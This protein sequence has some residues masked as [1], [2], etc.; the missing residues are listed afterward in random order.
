MI[1]FNC[2]KQI[3]DNSETCPSCGRPIVHREQLGKEISLRRYQRWFFY[4]VL[5]LIFLGMI[6]AIVKIYNA[7]TKLLLSVSSVQKELEEAKGT[8]GTTEAEL[9]QR[10]ELLKQVQADLLEKSQAVDVKTEE[11]KTVLNEKTAIEEKYSQSQLDLSSAEA[12]I[13]NLIIRLGV[14]ISNENLKK[15]PVADANLEGDDTDGDGLSD[16]AEEALG[17]DAAK[18]DTDGDGYNDKQEI[19]TGFN[20]LGAGNLGIDMDFANK[21]KGKILLQVE[22]HGEAWYV[23]TG[24]GERYFLGKPADAFRIMRSVEYWTKK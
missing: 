9:A 6:L 22:G 20:P 11:F 5:V 3:P 23:N 24:D 15:I 19:L 16:L 14:G 17:T 2:R 21:Q 1:C 7:N 10:E 4:G 13:Y 8:L 12:N 18:V